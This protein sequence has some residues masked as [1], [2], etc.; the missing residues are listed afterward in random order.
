[1]MELLNS[2]VGEPLRNRIVSN[3]GPALNMLLKA[4]GMI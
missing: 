1:M 4:Q 2:L 3:R